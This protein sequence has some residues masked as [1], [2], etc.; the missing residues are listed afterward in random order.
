[1]VI[2]HSYVS[3]PEGIYIYIQNQGLP[4]FIQPAGSHLQGQQFGELGRWT[5][6]QGIQTAQRGHLWRRSLKGRMFFFSWLEKTIHPISFYIILYHPI[7]SYI[8]LYHPQVMLISNQLCFEGCILSYLLFAWKAPRA[9]CEKHIV[10][11]R[12][13]SNKDFHA[14]ERKNLELSGTML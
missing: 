4:L 8:I 3:L 12:A 9:A 5:P 1:M 14:P 2:F 13:Q 11:Y 7:S 10:L 6:S